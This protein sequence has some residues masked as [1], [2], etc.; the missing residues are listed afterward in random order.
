M[1]PSLASPTLADWAIIKPGASRVFQRHHLDYCCGGKT[2]LAEACRAKGLDPVAV[3]AEIAAE[4]STVED[5]DW[6]VAPVVEL[7]NHIEARYHTW[8]HQN[9][10]PL[11]DLARKVGRVHGAEHPEI[12][13]LHAIV[14]RLITETIDH[15]GKEEKV[16]FPWARQGNRGPDAQAPI[17]CLHGEHE[18]HGANLARLRELTGGYVAPPEACTSWKALYLRLE[19]LE[20]ELM[21]HIHLENNLLFPRLLRETR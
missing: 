17:D 13:E 18:A 19:E 4:A 1:I 12:V 16:L 21:A 5:R 6:S 9:L 20:A 11:R 7:I 8:L 2:T 10:E 15:L 3:V 14:E